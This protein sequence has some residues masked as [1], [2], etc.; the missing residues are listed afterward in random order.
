MIHTVQRGE[1]AASIA[2]IYGVSVQRVR[3]DN[4]IPLGEEPVE[5]QAL[6]ILIPETVH[7]VMSSE[8]ISSIAEAYSISEKQLVRNNPFLID[9]PLVVG[10]Y[11]VISYRD[12]SY[13]PLRVTGYAYQNTSLANL[14]EAL[15]Y[16]TDLGVFSYGFT[17]DGA[18][19]APP[20]E[21]LLEEA[22]RFEVN[23]ILVLTP[24]S[25]LLAFDNSLINGLVN[26]I[27]AQERLLGEVLEVMYQKGYTG[28]DMDFEYIEGANRDAYTAFVQRT[29]DLMH[30][31]GFTINVALA[32]K[33]SPDQRGLL[34]E[35]ID[36][37][38]LGKAADSVLLM[39]YEWGYTY[40]PPMAVAPI[41][42]VTQVLEYALS[43]IPRQK[44]DLGIPN[45]GYDWPVPYI[46]GET[47]ARTIGNMQAVEIAR[48]NGTVI[49][50]DET[51]QAPNFTYPEREVWFEDVRSIDRKFDLIE[52]Y[53]LRGAG[54]WNLL[55]SFR[56]NWLLLNE[57]FL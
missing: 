29:A 51:S 28:I 23:P 20:D 19:I 18:L 52:N 34:Y 46:R 53:G 25:D 2:N 8:T 21:Q 9:L 14:R 56:P 40:G 45:Y 50:F 30:A 3:Y 54:Y 12:K 16:L 55:R 10:D 47:M 35:G 17:P 36:Y 44:I 31:N 49:Q 13:Y 22:A 26:N 15:L 38:A 24:S 48:N 27:P 11:L 41:P 43:E 1:T 57:K 39:T 42:Q 4:A 7:R 5:G 33:T 6:L 37:R 32:P